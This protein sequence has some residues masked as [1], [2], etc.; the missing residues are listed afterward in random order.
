IPVKMKSRAFQQIFGGST[1]G[2]TV[3]GDITINGGFRHEKRSEVKTALTRGSDYNF[4]MNQT[5]RFKVQGR[6]GEKVTVGVDQDS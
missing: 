3:T 4:K 5:Q 1:V 6:V 2:L